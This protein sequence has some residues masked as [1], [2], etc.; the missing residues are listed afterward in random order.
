MHHFAATSRH[1]GRA[2]PKL[3]LAVAGYARKHVVQ[4]VTDELM[5]DLGAP[6]P[7]AEAGVA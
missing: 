1:A 2:E 4:V 6:E 5:V 3:S 7:S